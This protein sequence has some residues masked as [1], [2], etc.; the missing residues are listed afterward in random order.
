M[1]IFGTR[2]YGRVDRLSNGW[3]V[4]TRFGHLYWVP[5]VPAG[6]WLITAEQ[7]RGW[8]GIQIPLSGRSIV[9]GYARAATVV[10]A[11]AALIFAI[12]KFDGRHEVPEEA[13][14]VAVALAAIGAVV[15]SNIAWRKA[16]E[17]RE[18]ALIRLIEAKQ[19]SGTLPAAR[20]FDVAPPP[21]PTVP[22]AEPAGADVPKA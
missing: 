9:M 2:L 15:L 11:I 19:I 10:A 5:L 17:E 1:I 20:G 13:I 7:G 12:A 3:F 18:L 4:A 22:V 6:S 21:M 14:A 8:S 16:S